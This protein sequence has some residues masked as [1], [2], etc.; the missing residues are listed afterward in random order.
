[1]SASLTLRF[2]AGAVAVCCATGAWAQP[3]TAKGTTSF[4]TRSI[5]LIVGFPPGGGADLLARIIGE[6]MSEDL[7]QQ[8]V[9]DNRGG[10]GG[11]IATNMVAKAAPD[12]YNL[13]LMSIGIAFAPAL[14][15]NLPYDLEK[16]LVPVSLLVTQPCVLAI[17]P[18]VPAKT[19]KEFVALAKSKPGE[20][21][22]SSSGSGSAAHLAAELFRATANI[23]IGHVPYKGGPQIIT[24]LL[25]GE[26]HMVIAGM[27]TVQPH[28]RAGK[29][30]GLATTGITRAKAAPELPT[31]AE[32]GLPGAEFDIWYGMLVPAA[33]P[34][35][36]VKTINQ[37][38]NRVLAAP[39]V[40][41]RIAGAGFEPLGGT[42]EKFATYL[43]AELKKWSAV[44]R[45]AGIRG[46]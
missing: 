11:T 25:A 17:H 24:S 10:G 23:N 41:E 44:V 8:I 30:R 38:F 21:L 18:S 36:I 13:L 42:Q 31:I 1:M 9:V 46:G 20:F 26:V 43:K 16:D 4:P 22:Y 15:R 35:P 19:V 2:F 28:V 12:G 32:A 6:K 34:A 14:Y 33:T 39:D 45:I 7:K 37:S 40:Q 29:L 5:R 3:S 27:A